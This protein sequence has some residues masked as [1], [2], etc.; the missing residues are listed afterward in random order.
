MGLTIAV[1]I[2]SVML[3][4][5]RYIYRKA[6]NDCAGF[7]VNLMW[8]KLSVEASKNIFCKVGLLVSP[9]HVLYFQEVLTK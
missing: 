5:D 7:E 2:R 6:S 8:V 3:K 4:W 9:E 1:L